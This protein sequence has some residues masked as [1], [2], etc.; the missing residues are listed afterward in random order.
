MSIAKI[1]YLSGWF[2]CCIFW[3][4]IVPVVLI[5]HWCLLSIWWHLRLLTVMFWNLVILWIH[6]PIVYTNTYRSRTPGR[7][8]DTHVVKLKQVISSCGHRWVQCFNQK[9]E[10]LLRRGY[11]FLVQP[12]NVSISSES[13]FSFWNSIRIITVPSLSIC[14]LLDCKGSFSSFFRMI[15]KIW[16]TLLTCT[17]IIAHKGT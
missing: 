16:I 7:L 5:Q 14:C 9:P 11:Y 3:L 17:P 2:H 6:L 4:V 1:Q 13:W 12:S 15:A 8:K 10:N